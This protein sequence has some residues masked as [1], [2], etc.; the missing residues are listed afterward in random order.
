MPTKNDGLPTGMDMLR[1]LFGVVVTGYPEQ[2]VPGMCE[3]VRQVKRD[4]AEMQ[5]DLADVRDRVL[6]LEATPAQQALQDKERREEGRHLTLRYVLANA[7]THLLPAALGGAV[8]AFGV[9][10]AWARGVH[11]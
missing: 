2:N 6:K 10:E 5:I 7:V 3:D 11:P 1:Q 9:A 4:V 8:A